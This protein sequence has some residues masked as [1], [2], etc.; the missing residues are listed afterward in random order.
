MNDELIT[1]IKQVKLGDLLYYVSEYSNGPRYGKI[2]DIHYDGQ[3]K[4]WATHWT[5]NKQTAID[6]YVKGEKDSHITINDN[7][8]IYKVHQDWRSKLK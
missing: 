4:L 1:D 5:N 6:K 8:P 3:W 7:Y 2:T